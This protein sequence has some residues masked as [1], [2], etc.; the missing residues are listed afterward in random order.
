MGY[1]S[2]PCLRTFRKLGGIEETMS[3]KKNDAGKPEPADALEPG[4]A[5]P[6]FAPRADPDRSPSLA[7]YRGRPLIMTFYPADWSPVCSDQ[8]ALYNE[9]LPEFQRYGAGLVGISVDGVWCHRAFAADRKL[10]FP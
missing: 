4:T 2:S 9:V 5:A 8:L 7:D 3:S 1:E 10:E 6:D